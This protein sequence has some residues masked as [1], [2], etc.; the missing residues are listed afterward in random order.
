MSFD[1]HRAGELLGFSRRFVMFKAAEVEATKGNFQQVHNSCRELSDQYPGKET[2]EL[3]L[4]LIE[5]LQSHLTL[6]DE[7]IKL[8]SV[9]FSIG[10]LALLNSNESNLLII[11]G[12]VKRLE[13]YLNILMKSDLGAYQLTLEN[14]SISSLEADKIVFG[15]YQ[16]KG[17]ILS[18]QE[19]S[20]LLGHFITK[21]DRNSNDTFISSGIK[22]VEKC[23]HNRNFQSCL[24]VC[25]LLKEVLIES[26]EPLNERIESL[27]GD[28]LGEFVQDV[29]SI[30]ESNNHLAFNI[31]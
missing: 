24:R 22:V 5:V 23:L 30:Y 31:K 29:S 20:P 7:S 15:F 10:Q 6:N 9:M 8:A 2:A 12:M 27:L 25:L 18:A 14:N 28:C 4:N 3:L 13:M 19:V 1:V 17:L 21:I 16:E 11:L 26:G